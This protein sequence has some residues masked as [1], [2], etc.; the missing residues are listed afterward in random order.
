MSL[1]KI[2]S[3]IRQLEDQYFIDT[4]ELGKVMVVASITIFFVAGYALTTFTDA[5]K[6]IDSLEENQRYLQGIL[7]DENFQESYEAIQT[8][9]SEQVGLQFEQALDA[10][11][12]MNNTIEYTEIAN[13]ELDRKT[14]LY[15][16]VVLISI[17]SSI[18]GLTLIFL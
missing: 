2:R 1:E 15:Q 6:Q 13:K 17:L 4:T 11:E 14:Q 18:V 5:Q 16:W 7:E 12:Q 10:Y 8:T 3:N 9:P